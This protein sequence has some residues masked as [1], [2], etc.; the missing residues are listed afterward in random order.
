M[1][2]LR[3]ADR[4]ESSERLGGSPGPLGTPLVAVGLDV[5]PAVGSVRMPVQGDRLAVH[6]PELLDRRRDVR[7]LPA[8]ARV[9]HGLTVPNGGL[10]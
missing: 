9:E 7:A 2:L 6:A 1:T 5:E 10:A 3:G 8:L 4:G